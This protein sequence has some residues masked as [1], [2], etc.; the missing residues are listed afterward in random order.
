MNGDSVV[1]FH[2]MKIFAEWL[3]KCM[4]EKKIGMKYYK[5]LNSGYTWVR[6]SQVFNFFIVKY[7]KHTE[8]CIKLKCIT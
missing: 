5:I 7:G 3:Y 8:N 1:F 4:H 2:Y 6:L